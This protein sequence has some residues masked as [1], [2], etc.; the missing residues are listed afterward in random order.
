MHF[1]YSCHSILTMPLWL[2]YKENQ[3]IPLILGTYLGQWIMPLSI[4]PSLL[5]A[6]P[7]MHGLNGTHAVNLSGVTWYWL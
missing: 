5:T 2:I 4:N 1:I 7:P 6:C 3:I